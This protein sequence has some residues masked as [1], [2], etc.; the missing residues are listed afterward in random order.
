MANAW[1]EPV[2]ITRPVAEVATVVIDP[3]IDDP[4]HGPPAPG[5]GDS[6]GRPTGRRTDREHEHERPEVTFGYTPGFDGLRAAGLLTILA[7]HHGVDHARGGIFTLSMFFTLSGYLIATLTLVEWSRHGG[8]SLARFWERRVRRLLPAAF[9][10]VVAVVALQKWWAVGAGPHFKTDLVAA[11]GYVAN[12]RFAFSDGDYP[13]IFAAERPVQH[14]WSLA[15]EEQFYFLFPLLFVGLMRLTRG[16]WRKVG[17]AFAGLAALS[18]IAAAVTAARS[19]NS[20]LAYYG[21]HTRAGELLAG[22]AL[23]F[24]VVAEPVRRFLA[25]PRG[26]R[27][28]RWG[29]VVGLAGY[30]WLWTSVGLSSPF[31]FR[32]GTLL[33]AVLTSLVILACTA[34]VPGGVA[35]TLAIWPLRS[36]GKVSY[37]A[38]LFH[39]PLY[40]FLDEDRTGLDFWPLFAAR[41]GAT[42]GLAILSYHV[43]ESPFRFHLK[44]P[45]PHLVAAMVVPAVA[46]LGLVR[47]VDVHRTGVID[48]SQSTS[49]D[50]FKSDVVD[51]FM[52]AEP[53]P[54]TKILLVG[55]SV[56]WTMWWGMGTWN[57]SHPEQLIS[58]DAIT[59]M[60]CPIGTP[61]VS[62]FLGD[63]IEEQSVA[64]LRFRE[65]IA[66]VL[67]D[68]P[69]D[70]VIL[71]QGGADLADRQFDGE[72]RHLGDRVYDD[73]FRDDLAAYADVFDGSDVPVLWAT[74][75]HFRARSHRDPAESWR[76]HPDNDPDRVDRLNELFDEVVYGRPGFHRLDVAGWV[77]DQAG[78]EFDESIRGDGA[79]YTEG[80]SNALAEWMIPQV[81]TVVQDDRAARVEAAASPWRAS[82]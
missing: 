80:G 5:D 76:D 69:Y 70:A 27:A 56:S 73:W 50:P 6:D 37:A 33:N 40:L 18:F 17:W 45:R 3:D 22:V 14:F 11:L 77:R 29:G 31:V 16:G 44:M 10:T 82:P 74:I 12:W 4:V 64:C 23:A 52:M 55:D 28:V 30:A 24:L 54:P 47:V 21:T 59:A 67:A 66:E 13:A 34:A 71:S 79:H 78:G 36:L 57:S 1:G 46:V 75:P 43:V 26:A 72:W 81:L 42:V 65:R 9:V 8:V 68:G 53:T 20:E 62:R 48:V 38:Y 49:E 2:T 61:G 19:G 25:S 63:V 15:V 60:G 51:P 58:V 41:V 39:W 35:R 32:G 7:Y